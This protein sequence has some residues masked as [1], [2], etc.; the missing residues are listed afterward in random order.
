MNPP[1]D[2]VAATVDAPLKRSR[3]AIM[4]VPG[5]DGLPWLAYHEIIVWVTSSGWKFPPLMPHSV[6][7]AF[8]SET[9]ARTGFGAPCSRSTASAGAAGLTQLPCSAAQAGTTTGPGP[10]LGEGDGL[11][12]GLANGLALAVSDADGLGRLEAG[13]E[14]GVSGPFAVQPTLAASADT[15]SRRT[16]PFLTATCNEQGYGCVTG[17]P[18]GSKL[19]RIPRGN[20]LGLKPF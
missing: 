6:L 13:L 7:G 17:G 5:V 8:A 2:H 9:S 11:G 15:T 19:D 12:V 3:T 20:H 14:G 18:T 16:T 4:L 10:T 1:P